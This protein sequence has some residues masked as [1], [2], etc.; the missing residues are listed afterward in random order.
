MVS[1]EFFIN[2]PSD[3]TMALGLTQPLTE[4]CTRNLSWGVG[5]VRLTTLL[6]HVPIVLKSGILNLLEPY[7]PVQACNGI[8]LLLP[9][10]LRIISVVCGTRN[11]IKRMDTHLFQK[12]RSYPKILGAKRVT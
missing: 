2:N 1:L 8:A 3:H 6:L 12:S 11:T 10:P 4:M 9:L 7:G 5:C